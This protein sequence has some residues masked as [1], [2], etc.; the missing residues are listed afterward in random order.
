ME[1]HGTKFEHWLVFAK[2]KGKW[3]GGV[4]EEATAKALYKSHEGIK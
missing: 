4:V 2:H 3:I 1:K